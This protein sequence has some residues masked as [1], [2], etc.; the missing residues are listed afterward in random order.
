[1]KRI[2]QAWYTGEPSAQEYGKAMDS[3]HER[4]RDRYEPFKVKPVYFNS[5]S[6]NPSGYRITLDVDCTYDEHGRPNEDFIYQEWILDGKESSYKED[7]EL[8]GPFE[9]GDVQGWSQ[10]KPGT[11]IGK[12]KD[13]DQAMTYLFHNVDL[14]DEY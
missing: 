10:L 8:Y 7:C 14:P 13:L 6:A 5:W 3:Y 9:P 11:E 1:M 12:F 4:L 2:I